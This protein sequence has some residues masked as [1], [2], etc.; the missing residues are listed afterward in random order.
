MV[1]TYLEMKFI[2]FTPFICANP[3]APLVPRVAGDAHAGQVR[4]AAPRGGGRRPQGPPRQR[5]GP[6]AAA[7]PAAAAAAPAGA[8][9]TLQSHARLERSDNLFLVNIP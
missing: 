5:A 1:Q 2:S 7:T 8:V 4:P 9:C 6:L 3:A